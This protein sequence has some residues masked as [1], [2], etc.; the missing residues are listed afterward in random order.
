MKKVLGILNIVKKYNVYIDITSKA[1]LCINFYRFHNL[2]YFIFMER[3]RA[4]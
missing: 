3:R 1:Y 4:K 2:K